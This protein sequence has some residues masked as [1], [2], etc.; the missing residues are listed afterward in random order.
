MPALSKENLDFV[1][2]MKPRQINKADSKSK[3]LTHNR[4]NTQL[5]NREL[6]RSNFFHGNCSRTPVTSPPSRLRL[7][8]GSA[9]TGKA[10][11]PVVMM[12]SLHQFSKSLTPHM[13]TPLTQQ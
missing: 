9:Q 7:F 8:S 1:T 12:K 11:P 10:S 6:S 3:K 2:I 13:H 5:K 4:A